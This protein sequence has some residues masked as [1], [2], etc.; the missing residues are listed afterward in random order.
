MSKIE[1]VL[2]KVCAQA[3]EPALNLPAALC[4]YRSVATLARALR[5]ERADK[6]LPRGFAP[7]LVLLLVAVLENVCERALDP[8][9]T[10]AMIASLARAI[11]QMSTMCHL[12]KPEA[13]KKP[14]P[15]A[16]KA[17]PPAPHA[18]AGR[19]SG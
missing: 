11:G 9:A 4:L 18:K 8:A 1:A 12:A 10:P 2:R 13:P 3:I 6:G 5:T 14:N 19:R 16:P 17:Q 15:F 7:D